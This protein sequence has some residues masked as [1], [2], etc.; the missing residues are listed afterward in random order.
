MNV[1]VLDTSTACA[2][3]GLE[4]RSVQRYRATAGG[5]RRHGRDL[6]PRLGEILA[7][8]GLAP[9]ELDVIGVG[10]GPGSYTGL[11][12]GVTAAKT[13]AHVTQAALVG[14]DSLEAV[15]RNAP[16]EASEITVV[17][18]AQRGLVYS[19]IFLREAP[20]APLVVARATAV[21]PYSAW[22]A[23]LKPGMLVLGPGLEQPSIRAGVPPEFL[24]ADRALNDPDGFRLI[25]QAI[26]VWKSGRR[27]NHW[28]LEP[29][30]LRSSAAE[31]QWE[32]RLPAVSP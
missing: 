10:L 6:V 14:L 21:E 12:V 11:R 22:L 9:G 5:P 31:E 2:V 26:D 13:L 28:L 20:A 16:S 29:R 4:V 30:Y 25:E 27:E 8:A 24:A 7:D 18:D 15:A 19:A 17:A 1:L 3:I 23:R 32:A